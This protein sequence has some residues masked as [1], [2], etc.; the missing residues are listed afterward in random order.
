[1]TNRLTRLL[2]ALA[3]LA[4]GF[5]AARRMTGDDEI[6]VPDGTWEPAAE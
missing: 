2:A 1:M 6:P 3:A 5:L 4:V